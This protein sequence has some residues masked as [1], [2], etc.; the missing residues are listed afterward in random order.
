MNTGE[1][2]RCTDV[3]MPLTLCNICDKSNIMVIMN[4]GT[5]PLFTVGNCLEWHLSPSHHQTPT[6][7]KWNTSLRINGLYFYGQRSKVKVIVTYW[8]CIYSENHVLISNKPK[9][10]RL[11]WS[12]MCGWM[13]PPSLFGLLSLDHVTK[14]SI[15]H[16]IY[17]TYM[18]LGTL[19]RVEVV[20]PRGGNSIHL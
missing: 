20:Q 19:T 9:L 6:D 12:P 1:A 11:Y 17:V 14:F 15:R 3:L 16:H 8:T 5:S 10:S 13:C 18:T 4:N 2:I 7:L